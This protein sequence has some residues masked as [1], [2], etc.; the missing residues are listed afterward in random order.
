VFF[1]DSLWEPASTAADHR[2]PGAESQTLRRRLNDGRE[3]EIYKIFYDLTV[4]EDR[5][6]ALG[7]ECSMAKTE[8]FFIYGSGRRIVS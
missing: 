1:I 8:R 4:L 5:L 6:H 3:F 2:L 7:W